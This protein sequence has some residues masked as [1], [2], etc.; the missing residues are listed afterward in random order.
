MQKI[1]EQRQIQKNTQK[2]RS[3]KTN[4]NF[5][6]NDSWW[7]RPNLVDPRFS[8]RSIVKFWAIFL[9]LFLI[10]IIGS[11]SSS[12]EDDFIQNLKAAKERR[13]KEQETKQWYEMMKAHP[14][15]FE[16]K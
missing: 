6:Y 7:D 13:I 5:E 14:E 12:S 2:I 1:I 4:S 3:V 16:R 11:V 15:A 8:N 10:I 9:I